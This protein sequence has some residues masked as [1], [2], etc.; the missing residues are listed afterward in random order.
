MVGP[1][2]HL[3]RAFE[4]ALTRVGCERMTQGVAADGYSCRDGEVALGLYRDRRDL[5]PLGVVRVGHHG[6]HRH[7]GPGCRVAFR[8]EPARARL[9]GPTLRY[10]LMSTGGQRTAE[11]WGPRNTHYWTRVT[12]APLG[13]DQVAASEIGAVVQALFTELDACWAAVNV[14]PTTPPRPEPEVPTHRYVAW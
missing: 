3:W 11:P 8:I 5:P 13:A 14:E 10:H 9:L 2:E 12:S 6:A 7:L 4:T 1:Y